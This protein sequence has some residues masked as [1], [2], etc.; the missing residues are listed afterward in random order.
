M[1]SLPDIL[2]FFLLQLPLGL[3]MWLCVGMGCKFAWD[4]LRGNL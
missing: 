1:I 4:M 2:V 3:L